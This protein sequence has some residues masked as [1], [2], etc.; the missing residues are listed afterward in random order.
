LPRE[1]EC[2]QELLGRL[3]TQAEGFIM[4]VKVVEP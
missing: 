2:A 1:L 3:R 4:F